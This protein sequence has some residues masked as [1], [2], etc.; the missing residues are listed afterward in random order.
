MLVPPWTT[1]LLVNTSPVEVITTPVPAAVPPP[2]VEV[3]STTDLLTV[4]P[5]P[6]LSPLLP[7]DD[8]EPSGA[9]AGCWTA[10]N[11][12]GV[13]W[14]RRAEPIRTPTTRAMTSRA[15]TPTLNPCPDGGAGDCGG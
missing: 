7:P 4:S 15:T 2:T 6:E 1:W 13:R 11:V 8:D 12:C 14:V 10:G 9:G 3:M 5:T